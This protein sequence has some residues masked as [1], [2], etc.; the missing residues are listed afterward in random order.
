MITCP[1][2]FNQLEY[3]DY[4]GSRAA[5]KIGDIYRCPNA[6]KRG[7]FCESETFRVCGAFYTDKGG[8]L[9]EGYP[10]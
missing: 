10:C 1:Y 8:N 9:C 3:E 5:G 7:G 2:C 6:M 4:Y